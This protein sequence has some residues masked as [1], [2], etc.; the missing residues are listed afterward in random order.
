MDDWSSQSQSPQKIWNKLKELNPHLDES[1]YRLP[2]GRWDQNR[3]QSE[4][5]RIN[6]S[7]QAELDEYRRAAEQRTFEKQQRKAVK[8]EQKRYESIE[9]KKQID[10]N[11]FKIG[12]YMFMIPPLIQFLILITVYF[13][14]F[15]KG[16]ELLWNLIPLMLL[17]NL[18]AW[19]SVPIMTTQLAKQINRL[20]HR[21]K[22]MI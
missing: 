19:I 10:M 18:V 16:L 5:D 21:T 12:L 14:P 9:L 7:K 8:R 17:L 1:F 4:L 22:D 3:L 2:N 15:F 20:D 13:L 11:T 6:R